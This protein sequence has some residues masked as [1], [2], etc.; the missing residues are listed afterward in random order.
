MIT[1]KKINKANKI[2][3]SD[4]IEDLKDNHREPS[5]D[6]KFIQ[7][8]CKGVIDAMNLSKAKNACQEIGKAIK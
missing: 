1:S 3:I 6:D 8:L 5:K 2:S 4:Y 7:A